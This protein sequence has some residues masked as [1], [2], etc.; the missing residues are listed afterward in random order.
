MNTIDLLMLFAVG[1][2]ALAGALRGFLREAVG[3][4]AW[5]LALF[6]A[7]HF[8]RYLEPH[9]GGLLAQASVRPWAARV[10]IVMLTLFVGHAVGTVSGHYVKTPVDVG[11]DGILGIAFG[12]IRGFL[13]IGALILAGQQLQLDGTSWWRKSALMPYG[14]SVANSMRYLL[15]EERLHHTFLQRR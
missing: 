5:I 15:G 11:L 4:I 12:V 3:T 14:E 6:I 8:G 7:W 2:F 1:V 9:L 10:I 13:L